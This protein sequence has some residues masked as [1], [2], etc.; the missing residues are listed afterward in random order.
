[1][2]PVAEVPVAEAPVQTEPAVMAPVMLAPAAAEPVVIAPLLP[3]VVKTEPEFAAAAAPA[4]VS[5]PLAM[6]ATQP[7]VPPVREEMLAEPA[8][9]APVLANGD[10]THKADPGAQQPEAPAQLPEPSPSPAQVDDPTR[11]S[12]RGWWQRR[13]G[14]AE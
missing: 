1:M 14:G 6:F 11:P 10:G 12:R 9:H 5:E 7:A 2:A 4:A 3:P 13:F 8:P